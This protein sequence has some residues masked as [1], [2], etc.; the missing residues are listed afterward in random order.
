[1]THR[2][3][4]LTGIEAMAMQGKW[5]KLPD[6][7]DTEHVKRIWN[8]FETAR[9]DLNGNARPKDRPPFNDDRP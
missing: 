3:K 7:K 6:E 1:M 8:I 9:E 2:A 4:R 5:Q